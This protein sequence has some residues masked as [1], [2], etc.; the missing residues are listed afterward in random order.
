MLL[1]MGFGEHLE[2]LLRI[3]VP[4]IRNPEFTEDIFKAE[5]RQSIIDMSS[6][7]QMPPYQHAMLLDTGI[8]SAAVSG[9]SSVFDVN[10]LLTGL[11][12]LLSNLRVSS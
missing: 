6:V 2:D 10:P 3:V 7:Q 5:R 11:H 4:A 8:L 12:L 1:S 9:K